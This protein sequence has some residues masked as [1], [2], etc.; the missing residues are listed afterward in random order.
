MRVAVI[1]DLH[2][3]LPALEAVLEAIE[4]GGYDHI[5][6]TGD[7]IGIGPYP[8]ECLDRLL[9]T[10]NV[11]L[12]KGNHDTWLVD[13]FPDALP[14]WLR[15]DDP[16]ELELWAHVEANAHWT[17]AQIDP[18][19]ASRVAQWPLQIRSEYEGFK[20][21]FQHYA[22][23]SAGDGYKLLIHN[24]TV[25][26]LDELFE[27]EDAD[28]VFYGHTHPRSD[29]MGRARYVN[30]GSLGCHSKAVARYCAAEFRRGECRIEHCC[31]PYDDGE[32][33]R[34][35]ERRAVPGRAF[36]YRMFLGDRFGTHK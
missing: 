36:F 10:P 30:P 5:V 8:V 25:D 24:A 34:A 22:L 6:H 23:V 21:A 9:S 4:R 32:L 18:R 14:K 2:A 17:H 26:D 33:F 16:F 15:Q 1:T 20:V 31:E 35:F 19:L 27:H 28:I 7:V 12:I 11:S 29:L 3:N 13:G